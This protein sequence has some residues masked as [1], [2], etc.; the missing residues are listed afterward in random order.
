MAKCHVDLETQETLLFYSKHVAARTSDFSGFLH[1]PGLLPRYYPAKS[2]NEVE[3]KKENKNFSTQVGKPVT[4]LRCISL[5]VL[6]KP[7]SAPPERLFRT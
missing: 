6:L 5:I 3:K 7:S 1:Q 4:S 2:K